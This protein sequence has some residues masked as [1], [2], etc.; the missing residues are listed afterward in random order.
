ME[1]GGHGLMPEYRTNQGWSHLSFFQVSWT[2]LIWDTCLIWIS[3]LDIV[4]PESLPGAGVRLTLAMWNF[5]GWNCLGGGG[6]GGG[7]GVGRGWGLER[8]PKF[9][10]N[11]C[12]IFMCF[13]SNPWFKTLNSRR[14]V[15]HSCDQLNRLTYNWTYLWTSALLGV[16]FLWFFVVVVGVLF[17]LYLFVS[18]IYWKLD[19]FH[20]IC[21]GVLTQKFEIIW[22][23]IWFQSGVVWVRVVLNWYFVSGVLYSHRTI[24]CV[25]VYYLAYG[26]FFTVTGHRPSSRDWI[27]PMTVISVCFHPEDGLRWENWDRWRTETGGELRPRHGRSAVSYWVGWSRSQ[28]G[29]H[30]DHAPRSR[31]EAPGWMMSWPVSTTPSSGHLMSLSSQWWPWG[32]AG[33]RL[34]WAARMGRVWGLQWPPAWQ[35]GQG[36]VAET[37]PNGPS[38]GPVNYYIYMD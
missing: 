35:G 17:C 25:A 34:V 21:A 12:C 3:S 27:S 11:I 31:L 38:A 23:N 7:G 4:R 37:H 24:A 26:S 9:Y 18:L 15:Q 28:S 30:P 10:E 5:R 36:R 14:G 16:L 20:N 32:L 19:I 6:G 1:G 33:G 13:I 22:W 2:R 8:N 29:C